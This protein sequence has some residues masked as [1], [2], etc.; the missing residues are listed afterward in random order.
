MSY[1]EL[2]MSFSKETN[3]FKERSLY[4]SLRER[5]KFEVCYPLAV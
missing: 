3:T 4:L 2:P 5:T 1:F